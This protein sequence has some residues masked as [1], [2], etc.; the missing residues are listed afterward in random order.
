MFGTS[1]S[2]SAVRV[3]G[4]KTGA[5][6]L[7]RPGEVLAGKRIDLDFGVGAGGYALDVLLDEVRDHPHG[8]DVDDRH[9]RSSGRDERAGIDEPLADESIDG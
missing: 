4:S 6:R 8:A 2:I 1:I 9:N 3:A 5:T 7:T